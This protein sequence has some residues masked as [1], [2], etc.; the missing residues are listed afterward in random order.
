MVVVFLHMDMPFFDLVRELQ[1]DVLI[2]VVILKS[3]DKWV[4]KC[5]TVIVD[6]VINTGLTTIESLNCDLVNAV[7]HLLIFVFES[8]NFIN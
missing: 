8:S 7:L 4:Y 1:E 2:N 5:Q 3:L 6:N